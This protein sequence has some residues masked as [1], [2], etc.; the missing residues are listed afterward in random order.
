MLLAA[1]MIALSF[2]GALSYRRLLAGLARSTA[3][4]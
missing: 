3:T 1:A 4:G 2:G